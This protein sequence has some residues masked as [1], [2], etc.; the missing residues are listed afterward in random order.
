M[1]EESEPLE[2]SYEGT[3]FS[4]DDSSDGGKDDE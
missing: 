4:G 3:D 1:P 2:K